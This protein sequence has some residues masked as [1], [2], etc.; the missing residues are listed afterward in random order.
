MLET[1]RFVIFRLCPNHSCADCSEGY[2]EYIID[3]ESYLES[4]VQHKQEELE[5]YCQSCEETCAAADDAVNNY[6]RKL[7]EC[8]SCYRKCQNIENMEANGY[9][10]ASEYTRCGEVYEN[11]N[12]GVAYYAGAVC[13]NSGS[14]IKVGLFTDEN[15]ENYDESAEIDHYLKNDDGYNIRLSYHV[16]K[17]TFPNDQCVASCLQEDEDGNGYAGTAEVCQNLYAGSGKCENSHGFVGMDYSNSEYY[18]VQKSN[19]DSVCNFVANIRAGHYAESGEVVVTGGMQKMNGNSRTTGGQKFF[20][21]FFIMG[22]AGLAAYAALLHKKIN[23]G[24]SAELSSQVGA[25]A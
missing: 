24:R 7:T 9:A 21:S 20:L 25:M 15:C 18:A 11:E 14:R 23:Q 6:N 12:T 4:T 22:S 16:L 17:Q 2:G 8:D 1:K 10:D 5:N 13:T 3:L 19:E